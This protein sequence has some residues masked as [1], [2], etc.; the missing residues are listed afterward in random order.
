MET[1]MKSLTLATFAIILFAV[2]FS[3]FARAA[4][5]GPAADIAALKANEV[6][7]NQDFKNKDLDKLVSHYAEDAVLMGPGGPAAMGKPAIRT[8]LGQMISDPALSLQFQMR[9]IAVSR[10]SDLA[11]TE[12]SYTLTVTDPATKKP[13]HDKG[14]YV[15][16]YRKQSDG[17]WKAVSDIATSETAPGK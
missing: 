10:S 16:V 2:A 13:I 5:N 7:W 14:S 1:R 12:G 17:S 9:N 4:D 6:R 3:P 8:A 15:T 11:Y